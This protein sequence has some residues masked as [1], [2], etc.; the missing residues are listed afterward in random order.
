MT[1]IVMT[2]SAG[3]RGLLLLD[4]LHRRGIVLDAVLVLAGGLEPPPAR[5]GESGLHR[6]ARWPAS[7]ARSVRRRFRLYRRRRRWFEARCR[8][9]IVTGYLNSRRLERDLRRLAPDYLVLG[10]GGVLRPHIIA[11]AG[12]GVLNAHPALLPWV[13]GCGVVGYS[14]AAGVALGATVH[15]VDAG[16]DTGPVVARRLLPVPPG[17]C[18]LADLEA[19][20]DE[21]AAEL[22]V[23]VV[24]ALVRRGERPA[25]TPHAERFPLHR[26]AAADVDR[27]AHEALAAAGRAAEL[28]DRW[29]PSAIDAAW[30]LPAGRPDRGSPG[31]GVEC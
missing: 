25:G 30:A 13:R 9:V 12:S 5:P 20:A 17:P 26:L 1:R 14:L 29:S 23:D 27:P 10:G 3:H 18:A 31:P 21:A 7:A 22:L 16:I 24:E 28:F 8:R 6:L 4:R 11:T 15:L 2:T 19:A